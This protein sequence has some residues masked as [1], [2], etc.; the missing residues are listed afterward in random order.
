M[1]RAFEIVLLGEHFDA[2]AAK[3]LGLINKV[4]KKTSLLK[5]TNDLAEKLASGPSLAHAKSKQ[6]LYSS[7]ENH[8]FP[9][10]NIDLIQRPIISDQ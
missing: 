5:E 1:K 6:L 2:I 8:L 9:T 3:R 10:E 4:V 7:H